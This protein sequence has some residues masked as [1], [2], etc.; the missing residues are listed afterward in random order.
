MGIFADDLDIIKVAIGLFWSILFLQS[1]V[2]KVID[3][4]GNASWLSSHFEKSILK[5]VVTPML[6]ML[7][8]VE[9][10]AGGLSLAGVVQV[11]LSGKTYWLSLGVITS[12]AALLMLFFGQRLAKDYDGAKTIAIYFGV[13]LLSCMMLIN[14]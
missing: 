7:T 1:G 8:L 9:L 2:D 11:I 3:W 13:A 4:K 5:G 14:H 12:I 6:G 10:L